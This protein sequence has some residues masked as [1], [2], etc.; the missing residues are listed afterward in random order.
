MPYDNEASTPKF[1]AAVNTAT[2]PAIL[3]T[4]VAIAPPPNNAIPK[5]VAAV[6]DKPTVEPIQEATV[7]IHAGATAAVPPNVRNVITLIA[8]VP[9]I[10]PVHPQNPKP[11]AE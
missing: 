4:F 8:A 3:K 6:P 10:I 7:V 2:P 5:F 9:I 11:P 1:I